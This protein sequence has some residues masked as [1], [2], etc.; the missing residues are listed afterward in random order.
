MDFQLDEE[1]LLIKRTVREFA[2]KEIAPR[3]EEI[4][5]SDKFPAD[6]FRRMAELG[7]LGIPF[8]ENVGG[9]GGDYISLLLALEEIARV[10]GSVAIIL[11]AHT[12]L[13][14]E[15]INLFGSEAQKAKY[16]PPLLHGEKI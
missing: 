2:E 15:P 9:G 12:S 16:L 8:A 14:C 7:I 13:C 5:V 10:S 3:A 11:D 4:D 1:H 6:L